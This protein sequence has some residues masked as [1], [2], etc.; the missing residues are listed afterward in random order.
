MMWTRSIFDVGAGAATVLIN[1][2]VLVL[3]LLGLVID[4]ERPTRRFVLACPV[5]ILGIVLISGVLEKGNTA[6]HAVLGTVFGVMAGVAYA[7]YL[8]LT[9]QQARAEPGHTVAPLAV[10]TASAAATSVALSPLSSGIPLASISPPS[11]LAMI[12]LAV[13]GQVFAWILVNSGSPHL[14]ANQTAALLLT[15]PVAAVLLS[16]IVLAEV[17]SALEVSGIALVLL[18]VA[19]AN[20]VWRSRNKT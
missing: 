1:V 6:P 8:Y 19:V 10:A 18:A 17:P 14:P 2:Q 16:L 20:R 13:L 9:R 11:W 12:G 3:P 5:M 4:R 7:L 15:Q